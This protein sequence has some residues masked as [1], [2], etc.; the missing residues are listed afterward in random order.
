MMMMAII[1]N[2]LLEWQH[3]SECTFLLNIQKIHLRFFHDC[4]LK[5]K[6]QSL[7]S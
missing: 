3:Y 2:F 4:C 7:L 5:E 1:I 6:S